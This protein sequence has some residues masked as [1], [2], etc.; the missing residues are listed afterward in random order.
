MR[1]K[2]I[3][4]MIDKNNE[5]D[6]LQFV[7]KIILK[8][9]SKKDAYEILDYINYQDDYEAFLKENTFVVYQPTKQELVSRF[10]KSKDKHFKIKKDGK[11]LYTVVVVEVEE[12]CFE[13]KV[14]E[15]IYNNDTITVTEPFNCN[16][17]YKIEKGETK[18]SDTT[19]EYKGDVAKKIYEYIRSKYN[20]VY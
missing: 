13:T 17:E 18:K 2:K 4:K 12:F 1:L 20:L 15:I 6:K 3:K 8:A 5:S 9:E 14:V 16:N 10:L 11:K 7:K 19:F